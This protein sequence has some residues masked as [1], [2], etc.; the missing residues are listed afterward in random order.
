MSNKPAKKNKEVAEKDNMLAAKDRDLV[1]QAK[2]LAEKDM[3]NECWED[4]MFGP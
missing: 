1:K 3:D 2:M 4:S